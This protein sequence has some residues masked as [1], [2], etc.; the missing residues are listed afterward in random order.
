MFT[1]NLVL[2]CWFSVASLCWCVI[3]L[4]VALSLIVDTNIVIVGDVLL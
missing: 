2:W 1:L 4:T 3:L